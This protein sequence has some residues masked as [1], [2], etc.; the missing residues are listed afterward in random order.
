MT[1]S[2]WRRPT[3]PRAALT[4]EE[5]DRVR[6]VLYLSGLRGADLAD[7][8]QEVQ[9]RVLERAPDGLQFR[10]AWACAVAANLA[11]DWHRRAG[12]ARVVE[13]ALARLSESAVTD[14]DLALKSAVAAGLARLDPDLRAVL[15]LRFYADLS[16]PEIAAQLGVPEGTVKSRLHRAVSAMRALLPRESVM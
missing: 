7:A 8:A 10:G 15:V 14:P 6:A 1:R 16:V 12:R 2:R 13:N 3:R 5:T 9:L 4:P 11:R